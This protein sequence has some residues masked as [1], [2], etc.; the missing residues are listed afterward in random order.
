MIVSTPK[1]SKKLQICGICLGIIASGLGFLSDFSPLK[2]QNPKGKFIYIPVVK[3]PKVTT[4]SII[5]VVVQQIF[6][7]FSHPFPVFIVGYLAV[8]VSNC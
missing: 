4:V 5:G 8:L 7:C 6:K 1:F 2:G 3:G